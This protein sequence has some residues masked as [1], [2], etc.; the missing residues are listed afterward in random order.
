MRL[1]G[2]WGG[3][4][5]QRLPF[6]PTHLQ[7]DAKVPRFHGV[8]LGPHSPHPVFLICKTGAVT[9]TLPRRKSLGLNVFYNFG[10]QKVLW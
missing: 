1:L 7:Q 2:S 10:F 8:G 6:L 4:V 5:T 9:S 3:P